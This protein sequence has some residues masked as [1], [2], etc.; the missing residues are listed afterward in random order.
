MIVTQSGDKRDSPELGWA[1][2]CV[3]IVLSIS[4]RQPVNFAGKKE[5]NVRGYP[6]EQS[7][8]SPIQKR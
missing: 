3:L 2:A 1:V 8:V 6:V 7:Q 4:F 5:R